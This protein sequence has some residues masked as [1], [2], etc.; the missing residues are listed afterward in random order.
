MGWLSLAVVCAGVYII[1]EQDHDCCGEGC[2][3]CHQIAVAQRFIEAFGRVY[4]SLL[5]AAFL[6]A[7]LFRVKPSALFYA[8]PSTLVALKIKFNC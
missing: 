2:S 4:A 1:E 8:L 5:L 3:V 6:A 7:L